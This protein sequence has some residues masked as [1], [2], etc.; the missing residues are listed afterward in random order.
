MVALRRATIV[1]QNEEAVDVTEKRE[2]VD[3]PR[4]I[5]G[6]LRGK[7]VVIT[8]GASGLGFAAARAF[9]DQGARVVIVGRDKTKLDS[10]RKSLGEL[11][12]CV[13]FDLRD[14][15]RI[16]ELIT[17]I[18]RILGDVDVLVNNAGVNLKKDALHVTTQEFADIVQT[19]QTS[20]FAL[21][22][23]VG[24]TMVRR[25]SGSIIMISSM[26]SQ[27]GIPKVIGYT[28]AKS[29]IEGMTRALAVEWSRYGVRVNCI[30]PGFIRTEMSAKALDNDPERKSRVLSRTPMARLGEP[31]EVASAVLFL[32]S[33]QSGYV[34]GVVLPVDGGNAIGF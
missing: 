26:A 24:A 27:Y 19:N 25:R 5:Y 4:I 28:A 10:A 34:T 9:V 20:V 13:T 31:A 8:G 11:I 2:H 6:D 23:E 1:R 12:D 29:A 22:R 3:S 15:D 33:E 30:A 16:T 21:T 14:N 18:I 7:K 17:S 32:A